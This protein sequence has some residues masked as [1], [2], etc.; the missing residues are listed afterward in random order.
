MITQQIS[1]TVENIYGFEASEVFISDVTDK[2]TLQIVDWQNR[3]F[4]EVYPIFYI[5]AIYSSVH[6]MALSEN[7]LPMSFWT[8]IR[9]ATRKF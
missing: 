7:L 2:I 3:P 9:M 8:S 1:K 6:E 5:D 4:T